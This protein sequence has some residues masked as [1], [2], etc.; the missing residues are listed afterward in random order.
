[1]VA[2]GGEGPHQRKGELRYVVEVTRYAPVP[3]GHEEA[4]L[5][6][7]YAHAVTRAY[8]LGAP[9]P[10]VTVSVGAAN[11]EITCSQF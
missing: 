6:N 9:A 7:I 2:Q 8:H 11:L 3:G 4:S 5:L 1:V 10:D